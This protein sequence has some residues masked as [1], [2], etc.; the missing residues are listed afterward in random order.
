[1][2]IWHLAV[3]WAMSFRQSQRTLPRRKPE[4]L[5]SSIVLIC[6]PSNCNCILRSLMSRYSRSH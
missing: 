2:L 1:M 5:G 3:D 4:P 6:G